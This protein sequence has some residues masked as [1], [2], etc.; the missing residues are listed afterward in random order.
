MKAGDL[1]RCLTALSRPLG[2]IKYTESV[3]RE[4][5]IW[6]TMCDTGNTFPYRPKQL[7]LVT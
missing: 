5:R 4:K 2:L 3:A 1:V 6:V 7:E